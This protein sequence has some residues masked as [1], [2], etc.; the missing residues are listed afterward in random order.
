MF[1]FDCQ[2]YIFGSVYLL[3]FQVHGR[4]KKNNIS[5]SKHYLTVAS[6]V[7]MSVF[8]SPVIA[9]IT[10]GKKLFVY[11]FLYGPLGWV[12]VWWLLFHSFQIFSIS[13]L[14]W[15]QGQTVTCVFCVMTRYKCWAEHY[16]RVPRRPNH[17]SYL[18]Q[19]TQQL[20][21]IEK[22]KTG[23]TSI[24]PPHVHTAVSFMNAH[25]QAPWCASSIFCIYACVRPRAGRGDY[26]GRLL[27]KCQADLRSVAWSPAQCVHSPVLSTKAESSVLSL[28]PS[29]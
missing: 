6:G 22:T 4:C 12:C 9:A 1:V 3:A 7:M 10:V 16:V 2:K 24:I 8:V 29:E 23:L 17:L 13:A 15:M 20:A 11:F 5:G 19:V 21:Y 26:S 25:T 28:L 18:T 14:I 27:L